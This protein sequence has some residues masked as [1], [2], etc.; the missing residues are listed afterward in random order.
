MERKYLQLNDIDAYKT[1]F[2]LSNYVWEIVVN[3]DWF[4]KR[5]KPTYQIHKP[6]IESLTIE[7]SGNRTIIQL[8]FRFMP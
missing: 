2:N 5:T 8:Y 7:Q 1:A 6:E 3:W 4:A